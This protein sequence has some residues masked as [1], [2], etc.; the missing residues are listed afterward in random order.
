MLSHRATLTVQAEGTC[1]PLAGRE[2]GVQRLTG[3]CCWLQEEILAP[4]LGHAVCS[5]KRGNDTD[6][7]GCRA[8]SWGGRQRSAES[9]EVQ[10]SQELTRL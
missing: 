4:G 1:S 3:G 8:Q 6:L 5:G 2:T 9:I 7:T 10:A